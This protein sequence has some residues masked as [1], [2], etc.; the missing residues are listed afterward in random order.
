[1][2]VNIG[3]GMTPAEEDD[4]LDLPEYEETLPP[5][6]RQHCTNTAEETVAVPG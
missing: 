6:N 3:T 1:M 5:A 4:L 2:S